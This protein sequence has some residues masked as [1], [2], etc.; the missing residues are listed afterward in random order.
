MRTGSYAQRLITSAKSHAMLGL[1][2]AVGCGQTT[3]D[4]VGRD[5]PY[6]VAARIKKYHYEKGVYP[7]CWADLAAPSRNG[8]AYVSPPPMDYWGR[9]IEYV[10]PMSSQ[11]KPRVISRGR[12]GK[13][14]G[15]GLDADVIVVIDR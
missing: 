10:A 7:G 8:V 3:I 6:F 1:I 13:D 9:P 4:P 2:V 5:E 12:D 11:D 15:T 14:G